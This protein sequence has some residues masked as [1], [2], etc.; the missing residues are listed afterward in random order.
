MREIKFRGKRKDNGEWVYGHYI[1]ACETTIDNKI[2]W[3]HYIYVPYPEGF[4]ERYEVLPETVGQ[5]TGLKDKNSKEIYEGDIVK[6]I[7]SQ[8][9]GNIE[10]ISFVKSEYLGHCVFEFLPYGTDGIYIDDLSIL[11]KEIIGNIYDNPEL[12]EANQ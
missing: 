8:K 12:L 11:S 9:F 2:V 7:L 5:Y 10:K 3:T 1:Y 4:T 6:L